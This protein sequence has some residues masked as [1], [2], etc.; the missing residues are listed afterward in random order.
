MRLIP[1]DERVWPGA[2]LLGVLI[3]GALFFNLR[4]LVPVFGVLLVAHFLF[5]RD[6][7]RTSEGEGLFAP[8]DGKVIGIDEVFEDKFLHEKAIRIRIFLSVFDV[9]VTRSPL[10][11]VVKYQYYVK[12]KFFNALRKLAF[13][14]NESNWIG[15]ENHERRVLIRQMTG[16]IA[17]RIYSDVKIGQVVGR[18]EKVGMICYGSGVEFF[19]PQRSFQPGVS[20]GQHVAA[21]MTVLG[22]WT[23]GH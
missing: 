19:I 18:G 1:F 17:R 9:H 3:L 14:Y 16:A 10:A 2:I 11:G 21:G 23:N 8:A 20:V 5:F 15:I 13:E 7:V 6:P 4:I 12:G 22:Q